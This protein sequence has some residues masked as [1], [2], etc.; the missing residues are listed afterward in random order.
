MNIKDINYQVGLPEEYRDSA[1]D[2][3]EEAF[4]QKFSLAIPSKEKRITFLKKCFI[5]DYVIGAIYKDELI[6]IVKWSSK[7]GHLIR[8]F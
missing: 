2:L 5:L 4:G 6:G 8:D 3:Y 7:T 1:V